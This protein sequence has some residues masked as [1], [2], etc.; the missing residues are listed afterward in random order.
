[1]NN[2]PTFQIGDILVRENEYYLVVDKTYATYT[3]MNFNNGNEYALSI[4]LNA[5]RGYYQK[6]S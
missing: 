5:R 4:L 6:V 2:E 1:M 3:I